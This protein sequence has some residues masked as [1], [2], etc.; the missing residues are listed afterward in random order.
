MP[1][2]LAAAILAIVNPTIHQIEDG[3][4]V[5]P[6]ATFIPGESLFFSFQVE[7][8]GVSPEQKVKLSYK[9]DATDS[10]GTRLME[11]VQASVDAEL[12]PQD[13]EWKPKVRQT[14][15]IPPFADP[16]KYKI[17][18]VINDELGKGAASKEISF[19]V[20]GHVVEPSETLI[21]RN[22]SFRRGEEDR[23]PLSSAVYRPGDTVWA[24]FDIIGYK[25]GEGNRIDVN[26]GISVIA[27]S[28]KVLF[29]Q[30]EAAVEQTSSFYPHRYVPGMMNLSL[31]PNIRPGEYAIVLTAR[32]RIGNQTV[33][34]KHN[35]TIE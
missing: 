29:S 13:K 9:L 33:E 1:L 35:F 25:F 26:Y 34:S 30:P 4:P 20:R 28:G 6:G 32:D 2:L 17:S 3:P 22:F 18:V 8:H 24:R 15:L 19:E 7:G 14:I 10:H 12:T 27:P 21:V 16:G 11:T 31:Q 23:E 5:P